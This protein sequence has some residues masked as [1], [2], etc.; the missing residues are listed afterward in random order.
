MPLMGLNVR[1]R[2]T[3]KKTSNFMATSNFI[4]DGFGRNDGTIEA[5]IEIM[6]PWKLIITANKYK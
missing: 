2:K 4:T 6:P 1:S 5:M 3:R